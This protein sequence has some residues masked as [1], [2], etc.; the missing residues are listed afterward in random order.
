MTETV[1][2]LPSMG[3]LLYSLSDSACALAEEFLRPHD[4]SLAQWVVLSALWGQDCLSVSALAEYSG[5]KTAALSRLLDRMESR[6][7]VTRVSVVG[8]K[9]SV[10]IHLTKE[11]QELSHLIGMYKHVNGILLSDFSEEEQQ[12]LFPMLERMLKNANGLAASS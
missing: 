1:S 7:L 8:D 12:Q 2:Y 10:N 5:K 11:G 4:I 3:R 9:R 6:G